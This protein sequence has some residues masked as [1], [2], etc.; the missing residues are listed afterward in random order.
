MSILL[1]QCSRTFPSHLRYSLIPNYSL[2]SRGIGTICNCLL[3]R[4]PFYTSRTVTDC[5]KRLFSAKLPQETPSA[6][7]STQEDPVGSALLDLLSFET[8]CSDTLEGLCEYF[9]EIVELAPHLKNADITYSVSFAALL[10]QDMLFYY[11][12]LQIFV[13]RTVCLRLILVK[14]TARM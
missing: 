12:F 7:P 9:D 6:K 1:R 4:K 3:N 2:I 14:P 10:T 13:Y 5:N 11:F 8:I